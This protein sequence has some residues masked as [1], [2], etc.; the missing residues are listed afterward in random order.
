MNSCGTPQARVIGKVALSGLSLSKFSA[1]WSFDNVLTLAL[2]EESFWTNPLGPESLQILIHEAAHAM[3]MH[4]GYDFRK[5][6]ER[7]AGVA[8][9][10]M[11]KEAVKIKAI[12]P[13]IMSSNS[14]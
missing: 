14:Q 3:N 5:E 8:A 2:E 6:V 7:L 12:F 13:G 10:L 1:H 9:S 4:H 11:L